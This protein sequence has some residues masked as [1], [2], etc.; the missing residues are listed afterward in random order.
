MDILKKINEDLVTS[1]KSKEEGSGLRTSTLRM[2]KS[3]I[4][5]AEIAKR[6]KGEITEE[7]ITGV[8]STMVKQRKESVEQY[9]KANRNDLAEKENKEIEIIQKYLP[10]QLSAEE[11]DEIIRATIQEAGITGAKDMGRLMKE[12][13]PKVKGKADGKLVSQRVKEILTP[14][15]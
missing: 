12:L 4:K 7:D 1:M 15:S 5:N 11:V 6:G 9:L 3:A 14:N 2:I 10:E 8:L 13:M